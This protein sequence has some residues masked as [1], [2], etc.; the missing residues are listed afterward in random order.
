M[1]NTM[2]LIAVVAIGV[3]AY[4][5]WGGNPAETPI[6]SVSEDAP[7]AEDTASTAVEAVQD[8]G[9]ETVTSAQEVVD[10]AVQSASEAAATAAAEAAQAV[11]SATESVSAAA[12]S[13][14][15][16]VTEALEGA[17]QTFADTSSINSVLT[18]E[19]FDYDKAVELVDASDLST[20]QKSTL[21]TGLEQARDK[22]E[23]LAQVLE[24]AREALGL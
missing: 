2:L 5:I 23:M 12:E 21:K 20:F 10:E 11:E 24:Q 7:S 17:T 4:F 14:S 3:T 22:P 18:E 15:D 8:A 16:S 19:G 9:E 1:R 6:A 13:A